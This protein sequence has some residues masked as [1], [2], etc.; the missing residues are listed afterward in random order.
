MPEQY[1]PRCDYCLQETDRLHRQRRENYGKRICDDCA[2]IVASAKRR[3]SEKRAKNRAIAAERYARSRL[4][5]QAI[6]SRPCMDCGGSFP[7][8]VMHFDHPDPKIKTANISNI[9]S[10]GLTPRV[11]DE[12]AKCHLVCSN[13][14]AV[15]THRQFEAGIIKGGRPRLSDAP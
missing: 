11:M 6:R 1:S 7:W 3:T 8:Y 2:A 4:A 14:H 12:I 5:L 15:R 10:K 9:A 13:C